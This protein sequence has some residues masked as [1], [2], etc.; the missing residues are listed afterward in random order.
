MYKVPFWNLIVAHV[1]VYFPIVI[2]VQLSFTP[3]FVI[4]L[5]YAFCSPAPETR[6]SPSL[7]HVPTA[8]SRSHTS[9]HSS[10][11]TWLLDERDLVGRRNNKTVIEWKVKNRVRFLCRDTFHNADSNIVLTAAAFPINTGTIFKRF[12][13]LDPKWWENKIQDERSSNVPLR[14][15]FQPSSRGTFHREEPERNSNAAILKK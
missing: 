2:T 14:S 15:L 1:A 5:C 13:P 11:L 7:R 6:L 3:V 9:C 8:P 4:K 10:T 12:C